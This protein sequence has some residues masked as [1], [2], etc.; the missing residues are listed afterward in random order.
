MICVLSPAKSLDS[1][2][3]TL[4]NTSEYSNPRLFA[5]SKELIEIL[6][7]QSID[8][9]K[10]LMGLSDNLAELNVDRYQKF[11][12]RQT[13]KNSYRA[14]AYFNGDVY[15]G[16]QFPSWDSTSISYSQDHLRILSGLYGLLKPLDRIQAYRLEMGTRLKTNRGKNLYEFWGDLIAQRLKSDFRGMKSKY[17]VNLAS[18][19]YFKAIKPRSFPY[20]ILNVNFKEIKD[21]KLRFVSFS[22]KKARGLLAAYIMTNGIE[23][24][25]DIK[26]FDSEG[27]AL[28]EEHSSE[29]EYL[30]IRELD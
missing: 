16:L 6:R 3:D 28:S 24:K 9:L 27:Y 8:D 19:E 21:G 12:T 22:A 2:K 7:D 18:D 29:W 13:E 15:Q 26:N 23:S 1:E 20:P 14:A 4:L 11:K 5:H 30:F 10:T 25:E 17:L